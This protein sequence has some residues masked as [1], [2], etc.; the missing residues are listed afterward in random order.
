MWRWW[1]GLGLLG[2]GRRKGKPRINGLPVSGEAGRRQR[3]CPGFWP[4]HPSRQRTTPWQSS[5][6]GGAMGNS[7]WERLLWRHLWTLRWRHLTAVGGTSQ[8]FG[9]EDQELAL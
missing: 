5:R 9:R 2:I 1:P 4:E 8:E 7:G 3:W 6:S